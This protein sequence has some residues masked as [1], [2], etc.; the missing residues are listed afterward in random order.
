MI[1]TENALQQLMEQSL[2]ISPSHGIQ[3][4][5]ESTKLDMHW[6]GAVGFTDRSHNSACELLTPL[7]PMRIAS[8]TKTFVAAAILRLWEQQELALDISIDQYISTD[9]CA[10]LQGNGYALER[11]STRQLLAHTSGLFDYADSKTFEIAITGQ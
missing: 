8:T 10:I 6:S 1:T 4:H 9:H 5:L 11:I 3:L 2:E 7:H